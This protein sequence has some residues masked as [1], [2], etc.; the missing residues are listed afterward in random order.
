MPTHPLFILIFLGKDVTHGSLTFPLFCSPSSRLRR[1]AH[2]N[3]DPFF[4]S[5]DSAV[6]WNTNETMTEL[7]E[8]CTWRRCSVSRARFRLKLYEPAVKCLGDVEPV[9]ILGTFDLSA[10]LKYFYPD[11]KGVLSRSF[12]LIRHSSRSV[13]V[14]P[15][16]SL[17]FFPSN[18]H[19]ITLPGAISA[20]INRDRHL[21]WKSGNL[22]R[23]TSRRS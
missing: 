21:R 3:Y 23:L 13:Y 12:S 6:Q 16:L 22:Q 19:Y 18:S 15:R 1:D 10:R 5:P 20:A 11:T 14:S 2:E 17:S 8:N 4:F 7:R 9:E